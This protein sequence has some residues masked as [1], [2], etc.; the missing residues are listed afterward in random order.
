MK[1]DYMKE[2]MLQNSD[3][4]FYNPPDKDE[5]L[6]KGISRNY[7]MNYF[8]RW[9]PQ[10][11]YYYC[12]KNTGLKP[13]PERSEGTYS[14]YASLDDK[15]DGFHYFM[16]Y[17]KLG[18]GRCIEDTSHEIRDGHITREEGIDLVKKY[19]GEFPK[20]YF[21]D[22]LKYLEIDEEKFWEIVDSW[23]FEHLWE[24]IDGKWFLKNPIWKKN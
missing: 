9:D 14:K 23:R 11:N 18:L 12:A 8:V 6:K 10:E 19:D 15:F 4:K 2:I 7:F 13:N 20:K 22:F 1:K 3:L 16:R 5:M 21:Q 17:I 24:K